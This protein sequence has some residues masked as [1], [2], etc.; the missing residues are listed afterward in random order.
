MAILAESVRIINSW[1]RVP[2]HFRFAENLSTM[3]A[4]KSLIPVQLFLSNPMDFSMPGFPVHHQ[5][6]EPAQT[7]NHRVS[8]ATKHFIFCLC[9]LLQPSIFLCIRF[10]PNESVHHCRWSKYP[11]SS[12][13]VSLS[14]H[15]SELIPSFRIDPFSLL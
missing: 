8:D 13:S 3:N 1:V 14:N 12:F 2:Y 9:P 15:Y 4:V 7:Q 10:F 11:R 5:L 6:I